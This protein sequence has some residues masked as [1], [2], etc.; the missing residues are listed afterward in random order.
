MEEIDSN[1]RE[2]LSRKD[3]STPLPTS[4]DHT[5]MA[6]PHSSPSSKKKSAKMSPLMARKK[7]LTPPSWLLQS[8]ECG[9]E[10]I[11]KHKRQYSDSSAALR[12]VNIS[13]SSGDIKERSS[14][15]LSI[16]NRRYSDGP[17]MHSL[18]DACINGSSGELSG[19]YSSSVEIPYHNEESTDGCG[20]SGK[21]DASEGGGE[22]KGKEEDSTVEMLYTEVVHHTV[23]TNEG[24][25]DLLTKLRST[26]TLSL[27][28]FIFSS[29]SLL[30]RET[31]DFYQMRSL[32]RYTI[33]I[34]I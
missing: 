26:C 27:S 32:K 2:V 22:T 29:L 18:S 17:L 1:V 16:G 20:L 6:S 30:G 19:R 10:K 28:S 8:T 3:G 21:I 5:P 13:I 12:E 15:D 14:D 31:E 9:E 25:F 23:A 34:I 11:K 24:D 4:E 33:H 7:T